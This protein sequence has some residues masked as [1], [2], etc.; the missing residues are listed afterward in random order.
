MNTYSLLYFIAWLNSSI[1]H[2]RSEINLNIFTKNLQIKRDIL[3]FRD[4]QTDH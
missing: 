1:L 2:L 3:I 4:V